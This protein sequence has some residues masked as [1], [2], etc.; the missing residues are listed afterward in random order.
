M[1]QGLRPL[2]EAGWPLAW[3]A[4]RRRLNVAA[5]RLATLGVFWASTLRAA[6]SEAAAAWAA[7]HDRGAGLV[8]SDF[9]G[10]GCAGLDPAAVAA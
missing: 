1:D 8:P 7:W 4:V 3:Q 5:D 2:T 6:G 10:G 9:P